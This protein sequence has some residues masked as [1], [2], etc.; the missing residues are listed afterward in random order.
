MLVT[1]LRALD[2]MPHEKRAL[3][4]DLQFRR[5]CSVMVGVGWG[6]AVAV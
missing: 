3:T 6:M 2:Q 5:V 1:F 4:F